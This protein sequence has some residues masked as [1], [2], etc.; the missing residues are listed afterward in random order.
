MKLQRIGFRS[1][2]LAGGAIILTIAAC[3][4]LQVVPG[5][6]EAD[7]PLPNQLPTAIKGSYRLARAPIPDGGPV[8]MR[9][10]G[11]CLH[12]QPLKHIGSCMGDADCRPLRD[13]TGAVVGNAGV[14]RRSDKPG[15]SGLMEAGTCWWKPV[16]AEGAPQACGKH[17]KTATSQEM[18]PKEIYRTAVF[19]NAQVS[20]YAWRVVSCQWLTEPGCMGTPDQK[21]LRWGPIWNAEVRGVE[22]PKHKRP[23]R[24]PVPPVPVEAE[25]GM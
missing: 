18:H 23:D 20:A 14:C 22:V 24:T 7:P 9:Y 10:G 19:T 25:A 5:P 4:S 21:R 2:P 17:P 13:V 16:V 8:G 3:G 12:M 11:A 1:A 6:I 15:P